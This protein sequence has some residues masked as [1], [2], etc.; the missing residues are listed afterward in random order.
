MKTKKFDG[1]FISAEQGTEEP[2][3]GITTTQVLARL[4]RM[5]DGDSL[6]LNARE[7]EVSL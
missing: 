3:A 1:E 5:K 6:V 7:E 4:R 2:F